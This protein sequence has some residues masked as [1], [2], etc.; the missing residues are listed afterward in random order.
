MFH[1]LRFTVLGALIVTGLVASNGPLS[2]DEGNAAKVLHVRGVDDLSRHLLATAA[3]KSPT[4]AAMLAELEQSDVIV[5]VGTGRLRSGI[6]GST[7]LVVAT[8]TVRY[9]RIVL[10]LPNATEGLLEVL[11]HELRHAVEIAGMA[12]VR[13]EASYA[14]AYRTI[15]YETSRG[16]FFE[17]TAAIETGR[18]VAREMGR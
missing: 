9:L 4:V 8:P 10:R 2:A 12:H 15:G 3:A 7:Q 6:N 18:Q 11:G 5:N 14:A 1:L 16:G 17:T 13:D